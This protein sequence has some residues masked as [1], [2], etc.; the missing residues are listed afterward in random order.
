ML[1]N[2]R[3]ASLGSCLVLSCLAVPMQRN[4]GWGA[5]RAPL[6]YGSWPYDNALAGH[7]GRPANI[8]MPGIETANRRLLQSLHVPGTNE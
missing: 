4:A 6:Q 5:S 3:T 1:T 7:R 8:D 2:A